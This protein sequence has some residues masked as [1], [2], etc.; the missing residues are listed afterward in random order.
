MSNQQNDQAVTSDSDQD[1][2]GGGFDLLAMIN[3]KVVNQQSL[4][5][6]KNQ[7]Q[8]QELQEYYQAKRQQA[9]E[10]L[11]ERIQVL[12]LFKG[13][14]ENIQQKM[15]L[16]EKIPQ[17]T[18]ECLDAELERNL[19][20]LIKEAEDFEQDQLHQGISQDYLISPSFVLTP[21]TQRLINE[22]REY[23]NPLI[24]EKVV[25][26]YDLD[27]IGS[28]YSKDVYNPHNKE[29]DDFYEEIARRQ[30]EMMLQQQEEM[31]R[32]R[33][34]LE[35]QREKLVESRAQRIAEM[36]NTDVKMVEETLLM[37]NQKKNQLGSRFDNVNANPIMPLMP[38]RM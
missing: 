29:P 18:S 12:R 21:F 20:R 11:N 23:A 1:N 7:Q 13:N 22:T 4:Q 30:N 8:N 28:N 31:I 9:E 27:E 34:M 35:Q 16:L 37:A 17:Q 15:K 26:Y 32:K 36:T 2:N 14:G 3:K 10:R 38:R 24:L 5:E 6:Q 25:S 33:R 19:K